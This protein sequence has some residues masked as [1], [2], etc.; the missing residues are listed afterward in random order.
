VRLHYEAFDLLPKNMM[1]HGRFRAR[2]TYLWLLFLDPMLL[3]PDLMTVWPYVSRDTT[4]MAG[5]LT[6]FAEMLLDKL[7]NFKVSILTQNK[8]LTFLR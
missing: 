7:C 2:L 3:M 8:V 4:V 6:S 1:R 5:R